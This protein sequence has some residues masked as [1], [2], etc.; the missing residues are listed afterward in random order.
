ML[1]LLALLADPALAEDADYGGGGVSF[2]QAYMPT[3]G[4]FGSGATLP[5]PGL[6]MCIGGMG[7]GVDLDD[8]R[9]GGEGYGCAGPHGGMGW[10]GVQVGRQKEL[11]AFYATAY[12][13]FG[14]GG[15]GVN[16][17]GTEY[18]AAFLMARPQAALGVKFDIVAIEVGA[19]LALPFGVV[20]WSE[21]EAAAG[22]LQP[23]AGGQFSL[24]FGSFPERRLPPPPPCEEPPA[25]P[26]PRPLAIPGNEPP[27]PR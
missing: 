10:G 22:L 18:G 15:L 19:F 25:P 6:M 11:G 14:G 26:P 2:H 4:A 27:P 1:L 20:Q 21:S 16:N 8:R 3:F 12:G 7:F 24:L 23:Y 5:G 13:T 9:A 17:G